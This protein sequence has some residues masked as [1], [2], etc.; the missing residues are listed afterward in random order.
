MYWMKIKGIFS[1]ICTKESLRKLFIWRRNCDTKRYLSLH[2]FRTLIKNKQCSKRYG[3]KWGIC[4]SFPYADFAHLDLRSNTWAGQLKNIIYSYL[5]L[6]KYFLFIVS[7]FYDNLF[8][9][10]P[11]QSKIKVQSFLFGHQYP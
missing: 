1:V 10:Y 3:E 6:F 9:Q 5:Q 2:C 11:K 4:K 7:N 8:L